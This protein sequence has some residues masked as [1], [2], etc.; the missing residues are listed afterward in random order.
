MATSFRVQITTS[1]SILICSFL[2]LASISVAYRP[3]DTVPMSK[4]GQY[5]SQRTVWH[6]MI[7]RQCPIFGVNREVL[8]PLAKPTGY[9]GADPYKMMAA[10]LHKKLKRREL[11]KLDI[12]KICQEIMN[13]SVPMALRLSE[14][15]MGGVV[16]VYEMKVKLLL[17]D[18]SRLLLE[19][20]DMWKLKAVGDQDV[21][22]KGK[23]QAKFDEV[24]MAEND[25]M[26]DTAE[27]EQSRDNNNYKYKHNKAAYFPVELDLMEE[28]FTSEGKHPED[29]NHHQANREKITL[30]EPVEITPPEQHQFNRFERFDVDGDDEDVYTNF[31]FHEI[32]I[33]L[34]PTP[35]P[36]IQGPMEVDDMNQLEVQEDEVKPKGNMGRNRNKQLAIDSNLVISNDEMESWLKDTSDLV[37]RRKRATS[38]PRMNT[39]QL[40]DI[41]PVALVMGLAGKH[42]TEIYYPKPLLDLYTRRIQIRNSPSGQFS[43]S[44]LEPQLTEPITPI[45]NK[46]V[47][48]NPA[49]LPVED[50]HTGVRTRSM[51]ASAEKQMPKHTVPIEDLYSG[52]R[53]RSMRA[54]AEKQMPRH[55]VLI[56]DVHTGV[57]TR[58]MQASS[59]KEV[60]ASRSKQPSIEKPMK[61]SISISLEANMIFTPGHSGDSERS[62]PSSE[63]GNVFLLVEP[64]VQLSSGSRKRH[65]SRHRGG[66]LAP[67]DEDLI[68][69]SPEP[70]F[71]F[72]RISE[73]EVLC[74]SE[75]LVGTGATATQDP[76][77]NHE[78]PM[79]KTTDAILK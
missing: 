62:T 58:S 25:P 20:N 13:P 68:W 5:H 14:I 50:V 26:D 4:M 23:N 41:P 28:C 52:V 74:E 57:R 70:D 16:I 59:E 42:T 77:A 22:P 30:L 53:T 12:V 35:P 51:R 9:T 7:G 17:D 47:D 27:I 54:S 76:P 8:V 15:L 33:T 61:M 71:K 72:R 65:S 67:V 48:R 69:D 24:T 2:C 10:T 32:P 63:L 66:N 3:G 64:E 49:D 34:A 21:L 45:V 60:E 55:S 73:N 11:D 6:D 75:T 36:K 38:I 43:G 18:A 37:Q 1:L 29:K 78:Q 40:M 19:I 39:A 79:S 56:D 31:S 44:T 46:R